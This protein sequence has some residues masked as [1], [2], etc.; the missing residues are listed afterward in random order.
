MNQTFHIKELNLDTIAPSTKDYKNPDKGGS[1]IVVVG[2]AGTGKSTLISSIMYAKKHIFPTAL[3]MSG[4][5]DSNGFY[6][7]FVP[8]TFIHNSYDEN[9]IKNFIRRQKLAKE[10]LSNAWS[11][12]LLDD[13]TDDIKV[14]NT[15]LQHALYKK[16][17]HWR[18]LYILSLQYAMDV[19]PAIRTNVDGIFIL[20]EPIL[21]N[22][23][24]LWENYCSIIPDFTTFCTLMDVLTDDYTSMYVNGQCHTNNWVDAVFFYKAKPPPSTF[25]FGSKSYWQFHSDR[26]DPNFVETFDTI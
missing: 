11:I 16:G 10:H 6:S 25:R 18:M 2:K 17:R 9:V 13:C 1:K 20:R 5:E 4:S 21:K 14:L 26:H 23:R 12:L 15:P 24:S 7:N 22:R 3:V 19:K 8:K